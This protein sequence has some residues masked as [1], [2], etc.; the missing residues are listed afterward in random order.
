MEIEEGGYIRLFPKKQTFHT[1]EVVI[2]IKNKIPKHNE[3]DDYYEGE[4]YQ[5]N[6][7]YKVFDVMQCEKCGEE[8]IHVIPDGGYCF[9]RYLE[10]SHCGKSVHTD[11]KKWSNAKD[12]TTPLGLRRFKIEQ[13]KYKQLNFFG[14][15]VY[16]IKKG[17]NNGV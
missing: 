1:S 16:K 14:K 17:L 12:F 13:I 15:L 4:Y 2:A 10:C 7:E 5:I 8:Y 6:K 11:N 3:Q 9:Q